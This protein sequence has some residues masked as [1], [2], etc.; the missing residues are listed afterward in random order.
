M[1]RMRLIALFAKSVP[2]GT[3]SRRCCP[4]IAQ[5]RPPAND[6]CLAQ[7]LSGLFFKNENAV[8][9]YVEVDRL[10][11]DERRVIADDD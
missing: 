1:P 7:A 6:R 10:T 8:S 11:G 2:M 5:G 3:V 4:S 9:R